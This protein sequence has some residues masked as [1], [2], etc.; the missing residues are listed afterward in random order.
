MIK[1]HPITNRII[2]CAIGS[3]LREA[4]LREADLSGANL[5][6]ANLRWANL[7]G[8]D[9][10]GA[11]LREADLDFSCFPLWCGSFD[12]LADFNIASQLIYHFCTLNCDDN[13]IINAQKQL[14]DL[15][16]DAPVRRRHN[17]PGIKK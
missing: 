17:L 4:D 14:A 7:R 5:S 8:A 6:W 16:N 9:L 10:R 2:Y 15:A 11:D 13:R 1:T 3:S 12:V